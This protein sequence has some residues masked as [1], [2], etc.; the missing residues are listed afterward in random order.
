MRLEEGKL[1]IRHAEAA[2]AP[3]LTAWWNDGTVMAHAGFPKGLGTTVETVAA[4]IMTDR[5]D[6]GR[7]LIIQYDEKPVGEMSY[8]KCT[9]RTA[10]IGIKICDVCYQNQG[11]G[12]KALRL[13]IRTLFSMGYSR[14]VLDT[15]P[16]NTRARH[17]YELLGF[18]NIGVRRDCWRDQNGQMQSAVDYA[19]IPEDFRDEKPLTEEQ[20]HYSKTG[21]R[22]L[23]CIIHPFGTLH[24]VRFVV[25]CTFVGEDMLLSFHKTHRAWETQGGHIEK[26]ETPEEAARRELY[27]ESGVDEAT[28]L[29]VCD[30]FAYDHAG[31]ANGRVY[32]A[33]F[34]HGETLPDNEMSMVRRFAQLPDLL[35]Y[36]LVTPVLMEA[37][38][39]CVRQW[40]ER[41]EK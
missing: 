38:R 3:L 11:I 12:R 37:A 6:T 33:I 5:D 41:E 2:D 29:P 21:N 34:S 23:E 7:H 39:A 20:T 27:E 1:C 16:S 24:P 17:V 32:A 25:V 18:R 14:I 10:E 30:Y 35:T 22:E 9:D 28:I 26:G 8:R 40:K 4:L 31:S 19:L 36:P 15:S 13:L